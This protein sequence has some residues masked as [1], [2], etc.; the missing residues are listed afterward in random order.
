[1]SEA[2]HL[3]IHSLTDSLK[4]LPFLFLAY[5][6][7]EYLEHHSGELAKKVLGGSGRFGAIVGSALG[8]I[9]QCGFSSAA[10][11]LYSAGVVS[12]GTLIAVFLSTSDEMVPI[13]LSHKVPVSLLFKILAL[14]FAVA[15]LFGI[16]IDLVIKYINRKKSRESESKIEEF[17]ERED[18]HCHTGIVK[19]ALIHTLKVGFFVFLFTLVLNVLIHIVGEDSIA[20]MITGNP[21]LASILSAIVGLIPNCASSVIISELYISGVLSSGALMAGLLANSGVA[22]AVLFRTNRPRKNTL[23]IV[24]ILLIISLLTGMLVDIT[25]LSQFLSI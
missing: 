22:L 1:M 8:L 12:I 17:C 16:V 14:K 6:L 3:I 11:G 10:A 18:C 5:L 2:F 4:L 24:G 9:P 7:M 25:P 21:L 15:L 23:A 13:F 20:M 19:P